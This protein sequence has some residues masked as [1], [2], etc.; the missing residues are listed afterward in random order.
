MGNP[1]FIL[2]LTKVSV[3]FFMWG[4][5][6]RVFKEMLCID[7]SLHSTVAGLEDIVLTGQT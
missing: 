3:F 7:F 5:S 1:S 4:N 2:L 6:S